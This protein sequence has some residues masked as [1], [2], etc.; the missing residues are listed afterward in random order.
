MKKKELR[1]KLYSLYDAQVPDDFSS[2]LSKAK[3]KGRKI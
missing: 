3:E 1:N 2:I